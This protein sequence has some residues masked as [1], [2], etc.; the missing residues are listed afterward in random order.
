MGT[1]GKDGKKNLAGMGDLKSRVDGGRVSAPV[2]AFANSAVV[3]IGPH[4]LLSVSCSKSLIIERNDLARKGQLDSTNLYLS[5]GSRS[6][7]NPM[8]KYKPPAGD[9]QRPQVHAVLMVTLVHFSGRQI[10]RLP[11]HRPLP[12]TYRLHWWFLKQTGFFK[13]LESHY[14]PLLACSPL[15][16]PVGACL[17]ATPFLNKG[18]A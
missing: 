5:T 12:Q 18:M 8:D 3:H 6:K 14:R 17:A 15:W 9:S 16:P 10:L 1:N 7:N 11:L 2:G 4:L 13:T